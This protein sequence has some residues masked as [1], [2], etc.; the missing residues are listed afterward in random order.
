M[1]TVIYSSNNATLKYSTRCSGIP[2]IASETSLGIGGGVKPLQHLLRLYHLQNFFPFALPTTVVMSPPEAHPTTLFVRNLKPVTTKADLDGHFGGVGPLRRTLI[3]TDHSS[4]LCKG[5]G[6]V[7]YALADDANAALSSLNGSMLHGRRIALHFARPRQ[8]GKADEDGGLAPRLPCPK[9]KPG[10]QAGKLKGALPMRTVLLRRRDGTEISEE[11][12]QGAFASNRKPDNVLLVANGKEARCTFTS[13]AEAGKAAAVAHSNIL[14]ACIEAM[15]GGKGTRLIVRNLPFRVNLHE[16]RNAFSKYAPVR[17]LRLEPPRSLKSSKGKDVAPAAQDEPDKTVVD[18]AGF[19]FVEY[20]LVADSKFALSKLNGAKVGGRVI[21]VDLALGKSD[22]MK[23]VDDDHCDEEKRKE[24]R[25][26]LRGTEEQD[27]DIL[28]SDSESS[29]SGSDSDGPDDDPNNDPDVT[30]HTSTA[31][32]KNQKSKTYNVEKEK[33]T[34]A[35]KP[36]VSS[37]TELTRTVFVRNL[38]FETSASELWKAMSMEFGPVEQAVLVKDRVTG[39]P[40]GTAFVRFVMASSADKAVHQAGEGDM[41][42]SKSALRGPQAGGC[43]LQGRSLL[44]AKAVDRSKAKVLS[45]IE[46]QGTKKDDPRN[47]R[48]AWIGQIKPGTAEARGLSEVD[49]TRRA[50]SD[51]EKKTK[52]SRNPNAFISDVRLCVR[53]IPRDLEDQVLKQIF[54][55]GAKNG[56]GTG[57]PVARKSGGVGESVEDFKTGGD[58]PGYKRQPRITYCKILR[59]ET[60]KDKSKGYG[61]VQFEKHTDA[62]AALRC[63]NN[64]PKVIDMLIKHAP[65]QMKIDEHRERL[66][67]KQWGDGRRLQADFAVEDRRIVQVLEEVKQK[68]KALSEAHKERKAK[69]AKEVGGSMKKAS[70]KGRSEKRVSSQIEKKLSKGDRKS[71]LKQKRAAAAER[72]A[73]KTKL[74]RR[75]ATNIEEKVHAVRKPSVSSERGNAGN[76]GSGLKRDREETDHTS[77]PD[78]RPKKPRRKR[79]NAEVEKNAKLDSLVDAYKRKIAKGTAPGSSPNTGPNQKSTSQRTRWFE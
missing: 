57:V 63:V 18:C 66:L 12:A 32:Q 19:G 75:N 31:H 11:E 33:I 29:S 59:D 9:D 28:E 30:L 16:I 15:K 43:V 46:S 70:R 4:G 67:R 3:V 72:D 40:R 27:S 51:K 74:G 61:F 58:R 50:K 8:R 79:N 21:A 22:Y 65:S 25:T 24:T 64:N 38:L 26:K 6:F 60:R 20:F 49:L 73:P 76:V 69:A 71:M 23:R 48:L 35:A 17:E 47:L 78:P 1:L 7:H 36:S 77:R 37:E 34:V 14:D 68:G 53:N 54:L 10:K 45:E 41:S 13:W 5:F 44:I 39:R 55:L 2:L 42:H 62:F 52:L 56:A